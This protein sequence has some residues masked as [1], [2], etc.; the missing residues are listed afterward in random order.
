MCRAVLCLFWLK[1]T[2]QSCSSCIPSLLSYRVS[3]A[4]KSLYIVSLHLQLSN[5]QSSC[6]VVA[7]SGPYHTCPLQPYHT[8]AQFQRRSRLTHSL[9]SGP[10]SCAV[11]RNPGHNYSL[12]LVTCH[13]SVSSTLCRRDIRLVSNN[14]T[15]VGSSQREV[16]YLTYWSVMFSSTDPT[17]KDEAAWL[18]R[19]PGITVWQVRTNQTQNTKCADTSSVNVHSLS[20]N[21]VGCSSAC[22]CVGLTVQTLQCPSVA[23]LQRGPGIT[24]WQVRTAPSVLTRCTHCAALCRKLLIC[25]S[26][27]DISTPPSHHS[28]SMQCL[29]AVLTHQL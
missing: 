5:K 11:Q 27:V 23:W 14:A 7:I 17:L 13:T 15:H 18:Q 8:L 16:E 3:L 9:P 26:L 24:V 1:R 6:C 19:G 22:H 29:P 20:Y 2:L 21:G 10:L 25:M 4:R 12:V 28:T